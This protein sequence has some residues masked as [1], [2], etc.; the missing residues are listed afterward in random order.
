MSS[1]AAAIALFCLLSGANCIVVEDTLVT[2]YSPELAG[3]N[4]DSDCSVT[5][6]MQPPHYGEY[7]T[8]AC[9]PGIPLG[10]LVYVGIPWVGFRVCLD[11][12][13]AITDHRLDVAVHAEEV[14]DWYGPATV[15]Y[16]FED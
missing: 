3:I 6:S 13:G 14:W 11:R 5:A 10:T 8:V 2:L 4:C 7:G 16:V 9:G 12:G 15:V 1:A